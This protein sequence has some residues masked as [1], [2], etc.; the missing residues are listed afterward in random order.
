MA[1][2]FMIVKD[3]QPISIIED[4]GFRAL[5]RLVSPQY[6]IPS[7]GKLTGI[8]HTK[9]LSAV[10]F[11]SDA[12]RNKFLTLT[13][14]MWTDEYNC[15]SYL[16]LTVHFLDDKSQM[17]SFN[18]AVEPFPDS[19][20]HENIIHVFNVVLERFGIN[21]GMIDFVISDNAANIKKAITTRFGEEKHLSCFNHTLNLVTENA[22][23]NLPSI[24]SVINEV[25][26]IVGF[27]KRSNLAMEELRR[28]QREAGEEPLAPIQSVKTRW[29]SVYSQCARFCKLSPH[30]AKVLLKMKSSGP[31]MLTNEKMRAVEDIRD[32]LEPFHKVTEEM[33]GENY[34]TISRI[35]PTLSCLLQ[36][37]KDVK[38]A[39][40]TGR[41]L[42]EHLLVSLEEKF[43]KVGMYMKWSI[44]TFV[45]PRF[46]GL[47]FSEGEHMTD[48]QNRLL[49][50]YQTIKPTAE[51][52]NSHIETRRDELSE[53]LWNF[54]AQLAEMH[55]KKMTENPGQSDFSEEVYRYRNASVSPINSNPILVW[56]DIKA[57]YPKIYVLAKRLL[58]IVGTSVPSERLFSKSGYVIT[59]KRSRLSPERVNE[60][61]VLNSLEKNVF[62][63]IE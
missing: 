60:I 61:C 41:Q 20:T 22:I 7:R 32:F 57:F 11:I 8:L 9:F 46:K 1:I 48:V 37:T 34:V 21:D 51:G 38:T 54:H 30:I 4:T 14:D 53:N 28:S 35:I 42:R 55:N 56:E 63:Q 31:S 44:C 16:G 43:D 29:N 18:L 24:E 5:L 19:H 10:K 36:K 39:T 26:Q 13:T 49:E 40:K 12:L 58:P 2:V 45:D 62:Y 3:Y 50:L 6:T 52:G 27:F 33:S 15:Q 23:K 25:K 47:H 17:E 59:E